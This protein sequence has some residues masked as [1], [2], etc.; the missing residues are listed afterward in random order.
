MNRLAD[1]D[2]LDLVDALVAAIDTDRSWELERVTSALE[3]FGGSALFTEE[4]RLNGVASCQRCDL[5]SGEGW[6]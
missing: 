1:Q 3:P 6:L 5:C 4:L 2:L